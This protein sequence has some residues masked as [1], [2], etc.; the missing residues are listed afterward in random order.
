MV[1]RT[2]VVTLRPTHFDGGEMCE[3][4]VDRVWRTTTQNLYLGTYYAKGPM[5]AIEEA[6]NEHS[7][8]NTVKSYEVFRV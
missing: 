3:S 6:E 5:D 2:Y 1:K 8:Y 7:L 4:D